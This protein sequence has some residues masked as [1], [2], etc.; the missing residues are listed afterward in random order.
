ML[1]AGFEEEYGVREENG[2][3]GTGDGAAGL[4][5]HM[6]RGIVPPASSRHRSRAGK[7]PALRPAAVADRRASIGDRRY[8]LAGLPRHMARTG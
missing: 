1:K 7:M 8:N 5:R 3:E 2:Q 4:P 6:A